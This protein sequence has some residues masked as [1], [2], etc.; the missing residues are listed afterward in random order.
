MTFVGQNNLFVNSKAFLIHLVR[1]KFI[2]GCCIF[3]LRRTVVFLQV[4]LLQ[5]L[6]EMVMMMMTA[7]MMLIMMVMM[8]SKVTLG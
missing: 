2:T 6:M 4:S 5:V 1:V 3:I 7:T 8:M